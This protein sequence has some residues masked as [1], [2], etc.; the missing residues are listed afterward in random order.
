LK[1]SVLLIE[2]PYL[3][4]YGKSK[5]GT[6]PYFPLGL[7][8]IA[9]SLKAAG[10]NV[11]ILLHTGEPDYL[12]LVMESIETFTPNMIGF[13][14]MTTNY[15]NAVEVAR[16]IKIRKNIPIMIGGHHVSAYRDKILKKQDEFDYV[17]YGE[18]EDTI[19]ELV[20]C[21]ARGQKDLSIIKGL[22]WR[23]KDDIRNNAP[24]PLNANLDKI[25]FPARELV[26][27]ERFSTHSHIAGGRS[28]TILTSRGCPFH[29]IFCSAH[30]VDGRRYREHS[31]EYVLS[32]IEELLYKYK[33]K[34]IFIQDDTFTINRK[35][36]EEICRKIIERKLNLSFGC[37]SRTD[38]MDELMANLLQDAGCQYVVFGVESG[39][40]TVLKKIR[41]KASLEQTKHAIRACNKV[42]LKSM[43][44]FV[45]GF[46]F[47]NME[48]LQRTI[49]YALELSPTLVSFNP[50]V[51]FPGSEIF[52][53]KL[54]EPQ[55]VDGWKKYI[56][57]DV[58]PFSFVE[59]LTPKDIYNIAQKANRRFYLR[60]K[61]LW[62][63]AKTVR[64]VNDF[65]EYIKSGIATILR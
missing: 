44:S 36:V 25:P 21:L 43:A 20:D 16:N 2:P 62:K 11:K 3:D 35:R 40:A 54:H 24:R 59:G 8:Y 33:V 61:Q 37:F 49:D 7:G 64:S 63:I 51:P 42:G 10:H 53:E 19:V 27:L 23:G 60:P 17:I 57:V 48:T 52:D 5:I 55:T 1:Q 30:L 28:A 14:A 58:P 34:Y 26:D 22:I 32:E 47:D 31:V 46:P 9:S 29:C 65:K 45:L 56:T 50:L 15:P 6:K 18:G 38:I 41:K 13:S 4:L 12:K 39:D